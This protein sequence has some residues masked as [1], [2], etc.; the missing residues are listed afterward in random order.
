MVMQLLLKTKSFDTRELL[1]KWKN[2]EL[3]RDDLLCAKWDYNK[4]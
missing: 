3:K 4:Y 2:V 1:Q